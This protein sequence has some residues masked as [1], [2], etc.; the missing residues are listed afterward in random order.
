MVS[1]TVL[2]VTIQITLRAPFNFNSYN[3]IISLRKEIENLMPDFSGLVFSLTENNVMID[4]LS[5]SNDLSFIEA[6]FGVQEKA[7]ENAKVL[8]STRE[9]YML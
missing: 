9:G 7:N 4:E 8:L 1:I 2:M 5:S 3:T 6:V